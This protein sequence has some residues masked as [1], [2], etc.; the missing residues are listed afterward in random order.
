[1]SVRA[2]FKVEA[3]DLGEQGRVLFRPVYSTDP[4]HENKAFWD[5][6]L[7][8]EISMWISN[9]AAFAGFELGKEL[10]PTNYDILL[11]K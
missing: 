10:C 11:Q 5:A 1:M 7:A 6:T 8:G 2:K 9:K 3:K 4:G